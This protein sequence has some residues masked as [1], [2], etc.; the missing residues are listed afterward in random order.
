M[1]DARGE[2]LSR[3]R[4]TCSFGINTQGAQEAET[5]LSMRHHTMKSMELS[6]PVVEPENC[7]GWGQT[8]TTAHRGMAEN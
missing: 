1:Q 7:H 4:V 2:N 6:K 5:P 3:E 8:E